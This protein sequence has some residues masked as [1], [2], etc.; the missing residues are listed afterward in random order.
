MAKYDFSAEL[1]KYGPEAAAR[2]HTVRRGR[3]YC[4]RL[5]RR[6]YENFTVV[7]FL[8]PSPL[9]QHFYNIYAYCRWADDLADEAGDPQRS[10]AL[11]DWWELQLRRCYRGQYAHPVF[12]AL[13]ETIREFAIPPEPLVNLLVAFRQDQR[14]TRYE[15]VDQVLDYC[16]YSANPVGHLVLYLGRCFDNGRAM[17][18][19]AI[20]TGL[21]LV[22]FLQDVAL[23]W[24]RGRL[25]LPLSHCRHYGYDE[26]AFAR[27]EYNEAFRRLM[28][29]EAAEA[30]GW[31]HRGLPLV[32]QV[33][34]ALQLDVMLFAHGGLAALAAVRRRE[35]NV[36]AS[37]PA[38]SR[39]EK[40]RLVGRCWWRLRQGNVLEDMS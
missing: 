13:G 23:D 31:L 26:A 40:L 29:A 11:L 5:A 20:C 1:A 19:D 24:Q 10:L 14:V 22:N 36:W 21:Q 4:R 33:P 2:P 37:R 17:L 35:Y 18:A 28:A 3:R 27:Q 7:S 16:R 8:L 34:R 30:Q 32:Q 39:W 38:L 6:H 15:T 12:A 9:R 25:Y